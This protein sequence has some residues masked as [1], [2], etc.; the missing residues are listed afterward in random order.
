[1]NSTSL[2]AYN[3]I[4]FTVLSKYT[5]HHLCM[6]SVHTIPDIMNDV[7]NNGDFVFWA[8]CAGCFCEKCGVQTNMTAFDCP[9]NLAEDKTE[10]CEMFTKVSASPLSVAVPLCA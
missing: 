2:K 1:M 7:T 8:S 10:N 4:Q 5:S 6:T 9:F 3:F